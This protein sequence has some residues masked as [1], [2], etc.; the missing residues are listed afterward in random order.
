MAFK[1]GNN[2]VRLEINGRIFRAV[3]T[4]KT[5]ET[6]K[7]CSKRA[8]EMQSEFTAFSDTEKEAALVDFLDN[9]IDRLIAPGTADIIFKDRQ[10]DGFE[11]CEV[12][13]YICS[14]IAAHCGRIGA[15]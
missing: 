9:A 2:A 11:H 6:M 7:E 4:Q 12:F 15:K 13:A 5:L 3:I 8:Q 14:E 1:F 10:K